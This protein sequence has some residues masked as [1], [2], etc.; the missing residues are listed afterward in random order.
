MD[1]LQASSIACLSKHKIV[2]YLS[3]LFIPLHLGVCHR[4]SPG[5]Y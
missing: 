1:E 2:F 4:F 3:S 5:W